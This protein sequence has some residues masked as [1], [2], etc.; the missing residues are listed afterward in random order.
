MECPLGS[1]RCCQRQRIRAK[2]L[3][4]RG[5]PLDEGDGHTVKEINC[6]VMGARCSLGSFF[7]F[8]TS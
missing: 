4:S 5:A 2:S 6:K 7:F 1:R 3:L 8:N